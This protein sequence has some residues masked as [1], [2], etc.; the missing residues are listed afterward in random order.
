MLE[1]TREILSKKL[2]VELV[3]TLDSRLENCADEEL[4]E[5]LQCEPKIDHNSNF[6]SE[7]PPCIVIYENELVQFFHD[8]TPY[9]VAAN[10]KDEARDMMMCLNPYPVHH[11]LCTVEDFNNF[12][13]ELIELAAEYDEE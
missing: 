7:C 12:I 3:V 2:G 5:F 4:G 10:T 11:T 8:A 9:P 13:N 6:L 1:Q